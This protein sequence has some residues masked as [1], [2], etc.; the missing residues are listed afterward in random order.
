MI[1]TSKFVRIEFDESEN[2]FN[3]LNIHINSTSSS[4]PIKIIIKS[5]IVVFD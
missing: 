3:K 4:G 5:G 1:M 2:C